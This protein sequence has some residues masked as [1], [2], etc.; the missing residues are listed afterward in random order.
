MRAPCHI[1]RRAYFVD[2]IELNLR[3]RIKERSHAQRRNCRYRQFLP[4]HLRRV[5]HKTAMVTASIRRI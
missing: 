1:A 5:N 2:F 3:A 4:G